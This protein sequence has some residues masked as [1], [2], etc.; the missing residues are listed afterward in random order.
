VPNRGTEWVRILQVYDLAP[1]ENGPTEGV[2]LAILQLSQALAKKGHE[3]CI[4]GGSGGGGDARSG[5]IGNVRIRREDRLGLMKRT[6][7][8]TSLTFARQLLFP[9]IVL[10]N[11]NL[12]REVADF[13][14]IHGHIYSAGLTALELGRRW[15]LPVFNTIHGSYYEAWDRIA[16]PRLG[17]ILRMAEKQ[18]VVYLA[19]NVDCQIHADKFFADV[20]QRWGI[21]K[22]KIRVIHNGVADE[23]LARY[24]PPCLS[25][26]PVFFTAR[27]LVRKN[28][29]DF[30]LKAFALVRKR[31][32]AILRVAGQGPEYE[33]LVKLARELHI[34]DSVE[35]LG[36]LQHDEIPAFIEA[37]TVG[38]LPSL[39]EASS[40]FLL[41]CMALGK[42]VVCSSVG[43][44]REV[45]DNETAWMVPP[46]DA[47]SL[48]DAMLH[49]IED[50]ELSVSRAERAHRRALDG[51]SWNRAATETIACY[52]AR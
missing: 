1:S 38:V 2:G 13:D 45:A 43:G 44:I 22:G 18:A 10:S 35:F 27:R 7:S 46:G 51:Y 49:A 32:R 5:R 29:L 14:V 30:L 26:P 23:L 33:K 12:I 21:G 37:G 39:A 15:G 11:E 19:R 47:A 48:A 20:V 42:P 41:E 36:V 31:S 28:G 9:A 8:P 40:L 50:W 3:V 16:G 34:Q 6:W 17:G 52:E 4:L 25:E 24:R